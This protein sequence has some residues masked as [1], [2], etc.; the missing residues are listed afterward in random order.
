MLRCKK[1]LTSKNQLNLAYNY[2][3]QVN[4]RDY[5]VDLSDIDIDYVIDYYP[6][7][8]THLCGPSDY[9]FKVHSTVYGYVLGCHGDV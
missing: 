3:V 5:C 4:Y 1:I 2:N 9:D 7:R 8:N 6:I